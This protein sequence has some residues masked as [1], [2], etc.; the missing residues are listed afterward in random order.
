MMVLFSDQLLTRTRL[1]DTSKQ[2]VF[3]QTLRISFYMPA[4][5]N[6]QHSQ[7]QKSQKIQMYTGLASVAKESKW[8]QGTRSLGFETLVTS[9]FE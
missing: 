2:Q 4:I 1:F 7:D 3:L 8:R 5:H 9:R 6:T